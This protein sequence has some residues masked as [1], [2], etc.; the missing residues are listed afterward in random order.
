MEESG[1]SR[2]TVEDIHQALKAITVNTYLVSQCCTKL[3]HFSDV[4]KRL[5]GSLKQGSIVS[6]IASLVTSGA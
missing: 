1:V 5:V 4:E 6:R 3:S 2:P